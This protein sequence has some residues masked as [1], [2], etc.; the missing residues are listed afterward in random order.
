MA[1]TPPPRRTRSSPWRFPTARCRSCRTTARSAISRDGRPGSSSTPCASGSPSPTARRGPGARVWCR[2]ISAAAGMRSISDRRRPR[3]SSRASSLDVA[4]LQR[5]VLEQL[6]GIGDIR[7]DKRID[8]VGGARGT[9]A[10]EAAVDSG[11]AAV[12]FSMFPVTVDDLM[13]DL[14]RRRHHAA[15]VHLVRAEAARRPARAPDLT[16]VTHMKV[17]VADKFEQ[18][19]IEGLRAAGCEVI[20]DPDLKDDALDARRSRR[21]GRTCWSCA[22][23]R[24]PR[25]CSTPDGCR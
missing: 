22:A 6:L 10:L 1:A 12:A 8:F 19:G 7:T 25:R 2:C 5:H 4:L 13:V 18:S 11:K 24:S 23:R 21:P 17:L 14:G 9:A 20:S 3:T 16:R 15:Q